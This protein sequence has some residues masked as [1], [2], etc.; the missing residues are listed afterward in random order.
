MGTYKITKSERETAEHKITMFIEGETVEMH[1]NKDMSIN[2][3]FIM[4]G[5][6]PAVELA[7]LVEKAYNE[8]DARGAA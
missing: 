7:E 2:R 5:R 3:P 1:L 4:G 6:V 8:I